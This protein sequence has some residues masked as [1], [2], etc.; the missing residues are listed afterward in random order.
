MSNREKAPRAVRRHHRYR[1]KKNRRFHWGCDLSDRSDR[2][3]GMLINT[4]TPCS[5]YGCGNQRHNP[6]AP[7]Q[8]K[9]LREV[10]FAMNGLDEWGDL[11]DE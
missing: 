11:A 4:P 8:G 3:R 9:T 7:Y 6:F 2:I 10:R 5:C 1:L